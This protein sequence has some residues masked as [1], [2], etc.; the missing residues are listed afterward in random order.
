MAAC[1]LGN[2][3]TTREPVDF[4]V[5]PRERLSRA[6]GAHHS[7]SMARSARATWTAQ[8]VKISVGLASAKDG[9]YRGHGQD[10]HPKGVP[11]G[12]IGRQRLEGRRPR[13]AAGYEPWTLP[14][15]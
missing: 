4:R 2:A 15:A 6:A 12:R 7:S 10:A 13:V 14:G 9:A 11:R 3:A 8:S 1:K 5:D